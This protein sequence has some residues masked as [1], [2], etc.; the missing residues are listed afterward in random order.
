[1]FSTQI[2]TRD[3]NST[4][5]RANCCEIASYIRKKRLKIPELWRIRCKFP[6][7]YFTHSHCFYTARRPISKDCF[8]MYDDHFRFATAELFLMYLLRIRQ[9]SL[10]N[11]HVNAFLWSN[12]IRFYCLFRSPFLIY[13]NYDVI[14]QT[15]LMAQ[16]WSFLMPD[17][18]MWCV[19]WCEVSEM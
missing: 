15:E 1:M 5:Y 3:E 14:A 18:I 12:A 9:I 11:F 7:S 2:C 13:A 4:S 17:V 16:R 6:S 10:I 19:N 8:A